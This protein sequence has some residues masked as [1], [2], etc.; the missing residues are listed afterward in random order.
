M[1]RLLTV[2]DVSDRELWDLFQEAEALQKASEVAKVLHECYGV[3]RCDGKIMAT[4]FFE[5]STRTRLSFEAAMHRLGGRIISVTERDCTS[6][7]KGESL[8]DT[9][10]TVSYYADV[11][12]VR[13]SE[14]INLWFND[15]MCRKPI[16]N[17][18]DGPWNHLTQAILDAYT[19]WKQW[20]LCRHHAIT[21]NLTI[22]NHRRF[23]QEP[24]YPIAGTTHGQAA[25]QPICFIRFH[26]STGQDS[27]FG[28]Q[29]QHYLR[30]RTEPVRRLS[31]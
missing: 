11:L 10:E 8:A 20:D 13:S 25:E 29:T 24:H 17:A 12:V 9:I 2:D 27:G 7:F 5:P 14:P 18:G 6:L 19:I 15:G 4:L 23:V 3:T 28:T 21:P 16:I 26:F 31:G 30:V 1:R 22:G